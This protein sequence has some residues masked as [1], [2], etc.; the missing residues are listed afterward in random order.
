MLPPVDYSSLFSATPSRSSWGHPAQ[1]LFK[2]LILIFSTPHVYDVGDWVMIDDQSFVREF[3]L[4]S[5][6]FR[7][8]DGMEI[9]APTDS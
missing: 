7:R 8:V 4:F 3:G 1:T 9:I 6:T 2:S 5:T